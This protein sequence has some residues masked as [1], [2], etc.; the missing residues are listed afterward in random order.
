MLAGFHAEAARD[1]DE[2]RADLRARTERAERQ[3]DAYRDELRAQA[4]HDTDGVTAGRASR[5]TRQPA[6]P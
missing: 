2:L 1:R 6:Q 3:V 4:S 5:R